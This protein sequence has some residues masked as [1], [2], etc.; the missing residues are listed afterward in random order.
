M[1]TATFSS[2]IG[3]SDLVLSGSYCKVYFPSSLLRICHSYFCK[4]CFAPSHAILPFLGSHCL[5]IYPKTSV[6][7]Y[8]RFLNE[9]SW[10]SSKLAILQLGLDPNNHARL[11]YYPL[12]NYFLKLFTFLLFQGGGGNAFLLKACQQRLVMLRSQH[13]H[14]LVLSYCFLGLLCQLVYIQL[15]VL[16]PT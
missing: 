3:K 16:P 6:S 1:I 13:I 9:H 8:A 15:W 14:W 5:F 7:P 4:F 11:K 12:F 10:V 2:S